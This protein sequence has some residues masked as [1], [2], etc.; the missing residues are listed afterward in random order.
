MPEDAH[1]LLLC[2]RSMRT[3]ILAAAQLDNVSVTGTTHRLGR[4]NSMSAPL[5]GWSENYIL[6]TSKFGG[7]KGLLRTVQT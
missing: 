6:T 3:S 1:L 2:C 4:A 7:T 5:A